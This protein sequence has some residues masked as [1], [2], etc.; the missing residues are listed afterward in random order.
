MCTGSVWWMNSIMDGSL[1]QDFYL[2][3]RNSNVLNVLES[4]H[5]EGGKEI[6]F[7]PTVKSGVIRRKKGKKKINHTYLNK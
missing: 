1:M 6:I 3:K 7:H 4:S 5:V 2:T